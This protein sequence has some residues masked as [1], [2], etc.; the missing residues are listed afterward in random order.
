MKGDSVSYLGEEVVH[1][2]SA[3]VVVNVV[4]DTVVV[5]TCG[6]TATHVIPCASSVPRNLMRR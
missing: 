5:V 2:V 4:E 3:D 1:D 6:Q